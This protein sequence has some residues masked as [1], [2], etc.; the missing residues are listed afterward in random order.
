MNAGAGRETCDATPAAPSPR[1][2]GEGRPRLAAGMRARAQIAI[3]P[4][5]RRHFHDGPID[6]ILEASG[7]PAEV[8]AAYDAAAHIDFAGMHLRNDIA[9][10]V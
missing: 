1:L 3:L 2:W 6:L 7:A 8:V 9:A 5:G 4:D 10:D